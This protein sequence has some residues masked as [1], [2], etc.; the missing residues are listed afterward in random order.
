MI[1]MIAWGV[2]VGGGLT[3][4]VMTIGLIANWCVLVPLMIIFASLHLGWNFLI[5]SFVISS[6][7]MAI[8]SMYE[9]VAGKWME[10]RI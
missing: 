2:L 9:I 6:A 4:V 3:K 7:V 1:S 5:L 8:I 10:K